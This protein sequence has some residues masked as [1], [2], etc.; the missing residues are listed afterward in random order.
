MRC[1]L[2]RI[3]FRYKGF[4]MDVDCLFFKKIV[5]RLTKCNLVV[6]RLVSK[7]SKKYASREG[8]R[9][10]C[11]DSIRL[12]LLPSGCTRRTY[13]FYTRGNKTFPYPS[14]TE[15]LSFGLPRKIEVIVLLADDDEGLSSGLP[16]NIKVIVLADEDDNDDPA[17]AA[18]TDDMLYIFTPVWYTAPF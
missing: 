13:L 8:E 14:I 3:Y 5:E 1:R 2:Y 4:G 17:S 7:L 11:N 10:I 6:W 9:F 15:S 16:R 12:K 18:V